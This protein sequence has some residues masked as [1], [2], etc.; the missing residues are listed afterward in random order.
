[1][2]AQARPPLICGATGSDG[3]IVLTQAHKLCICD[4]RAGRWSTGDGVRC[5]WA[6]P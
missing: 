6:K 4:E 3:T 2:A 1:L 5:E